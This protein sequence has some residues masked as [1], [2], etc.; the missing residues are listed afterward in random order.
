MNVGIYD[1]IVRLGGGL[2]LLAIDFIASGDLEL[3]L[4]VVSAWSVLTSA[5]GWCPFYRLGGINTCAINLSSPE[6]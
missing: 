2:G 3:A 6:E 1:R 4:L 5:F